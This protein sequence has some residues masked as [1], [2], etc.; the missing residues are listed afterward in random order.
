MN[1]INTGKG[2]YQIVNQREAAYDVQKIMAC[3]QQMEVTE[4]SVKNKGEATHQ[5]LSILV[6]EGQFHALDLAL[7]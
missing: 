6:I 4:Q 3:L 2:S 7:S 1:A 5:V